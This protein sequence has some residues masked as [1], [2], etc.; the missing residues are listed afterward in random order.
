V[1]RIGMIANHGGSESKVQLTAALTTTS[2]EV[3]DFGA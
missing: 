2:H 1:I 3:K